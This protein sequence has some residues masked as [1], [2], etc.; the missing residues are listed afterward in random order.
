MFETE[1]DMSRQFKMRFPWLES[2]MLPVSYLLFPAGVV[3]IGR[4]ALAESTAIADYVSG[5]VCLILGLFG[6]ALCEL[7][8]QMQELHEKLGRMEFNQSGNLKK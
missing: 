3:L 7:L 6:L 8:G 5:T 4:S 1:A 2:A